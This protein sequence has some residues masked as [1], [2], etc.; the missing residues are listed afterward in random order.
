MKSRIYFNNN[1]HF[2]CVD[3]I[4]ANGELVPSVGLYQTLEEANQ[5]AI[6]WAKGDK[7]NVEIVG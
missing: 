4:D 3:Y 7:H 1:I 5:S 6:I 2:W